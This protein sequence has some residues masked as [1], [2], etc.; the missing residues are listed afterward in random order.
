MPRATS[1]GMTCRV[2]HRGPRVARKW[3]SD[4]PIA[5]SR[6]RSKRYIYD[7]KSARLL[8]CGQPWQ[9]EPSHRRERSLPRVL[10]R[11]ENTVRRHNPN[12]QRTGLQ[13]A[14]SCCGPPLTA[15][16]VIKGAHYGAAMRKAR[17]LDLGSFEYWVQT[18]SGLEESKGSAH[19]LSSR[20]PIW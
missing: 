1:W 12:P 14:V 11:P 17:D 15:A 10:A 6:Q 20:C 13:L 2:P 3:S 18:I 19:G 5:L 7:M 8:R 16:T 4:V 9:E